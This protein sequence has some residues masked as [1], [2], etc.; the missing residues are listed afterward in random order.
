MFLV[1]EK[2]MIV[3]LL[4]LLFPEMIFVLFVVL[5]AHLLFEKV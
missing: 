2:A 1:P 3:C 5:G 4:Y